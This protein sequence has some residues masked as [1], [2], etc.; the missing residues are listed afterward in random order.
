[1]IVGQRFGRPL[2]N[3]DSHWKVIRERAGLNDVRLHDLRH[4]CAS[5]A[6]ALGESLP[7]IGKLLGHRKVA[8]AAKYAHL[9]G[10]AE[11]A[12]AAR[13]GASIGNHLGPAG[14]KPQIR[15]EGQREEKI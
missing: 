6:L 13:V 8:T 9:V 15:S 11:K 4:S 10:D 14:G 12:A 5:R 7:T 2:A 1:M 3:F